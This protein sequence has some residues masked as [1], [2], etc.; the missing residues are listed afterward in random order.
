MTANK[1]SGCTDNTATVQGTQNKLI[2][3]KVE[4][5]KNIWNKGK[6]N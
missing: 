2:I 6:L 3:L 4:P 5:S 1:A